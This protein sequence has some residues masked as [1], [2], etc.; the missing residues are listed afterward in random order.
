M[1]GMPHEQS[2]KII[3]GEWINDTLKETTTDAAGQFAFQD[4]TAPA[5]PKI[6]EVG[7]SVFPWDIVAIAPAHGLAWVPLTPQNQRTPI[8]LKLGALGMLQGRV[9]EPGGNPVVGAKVQVFGID[10]LGRPDENGL[11]TVNRLNLSWSAFPLGAT[12]NADGRFNVAGLPRDKVISLAITAAAARAAVCVRRD[13]EAASARLCFAR[14]SQWQARRNTH[15]GLHRR[16]HAHR[17]GRRSRT[18][19]P[20][21][22]RR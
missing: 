14:D 7:Q 8:T 16:F 9:V 21:R 10:P 4:V 22:S 18:D 11:G 12:T 13:V 2:R 17:Q 6:A 1:R 20:S 3:Q 15:A 19:R 5:F